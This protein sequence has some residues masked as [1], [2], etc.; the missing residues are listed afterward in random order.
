M[1]RRSLHFLSDNRTAR[2]MVTGTPLSRRMAERFVAGDTLEEAIACARQL[3]RQGLTVSLDYLG[4]SVRDRAEAEVATEMA[5]RTLENLA[6]HGIEGNISIKPS[7]MGLDI[8]YGFCRAN[9]ERVLARGRELGDGEGEIFVRLD[10]ESSEYAERTIRLTEELWEA[11]YRNVGTVLQSYMRRTPADVERLN[12]LGSRVRLVKG[13]YRE[14]EHVAFTEKATVDRMFVE[15]MKVLLEAGSYPAI[16]THDE[17]MIEA[18]RHWAFER[19]ISKDSFEFQL[20]YGIR[21]DLQQKLLEDGYRV[22]IYVPFG[23]SWYPYLMRRMAER[24][25]NLFFIVG[26][27]VKESPMR[28]AGKPIAAGAGLIA[29]ALAALTLGR[30]RDGG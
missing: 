23:D 2:R 26:S 6:E 13:A 24:P 29:G 4:E 27:V 1:L 3:N 30:R 10:M 21:R 16:A 7:Q 9:L 19:G 11:G 25:A 8:E 18:T 12:A 14:P 17:A 15:E 28:H 20:L 5:I 22:R